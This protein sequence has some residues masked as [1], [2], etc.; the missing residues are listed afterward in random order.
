MGIVTTTS[1]IAF[2]QSADTVYDFVTNPLNW[3]KTYPGSAHIGGLPDLPLKVGDTW[4]EAGPDGDR[5]FRWQLAAAVRPTLFVFTS[6]GRLGHDRDGNGGMEGR[7]TVSYRFTRPG[8]DVTLFSRTMTIEAYKHA[9]L[10]DQLFIQ[11]NPAKID[12]YHEAVARELA[13]SAD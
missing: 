12:A 8:Q 4:E 1:E 3:T 11:A 9:P 2:T 7:I 10:P 6:I 13:R 5:I